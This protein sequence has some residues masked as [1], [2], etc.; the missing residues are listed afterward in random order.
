MTRKIMIEV[1]CSLLILLF[2]YTSLSKWLDFKGFTGDM[3]NQPFSHKIAPIIIWTLPAMELL[4][5][6]AL[7]F[8]KTRRAGLWASLILMLLFTIYTI[9]VLSRFFSRVPCSCGGVIKRLSWSQHLFFNLFFVGISI[10]GII[11]RRSVPGN[12]STG[13]Q[14]IRV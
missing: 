6:L 13:K 3:Y 4:I 2:L 1:I 10:A 12:V 7:L 9:L 5:V 11:L 8:E 14:V